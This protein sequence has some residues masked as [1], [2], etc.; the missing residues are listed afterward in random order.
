MSPIAKVGIGVTS[1]GTLAT[2]GYFGIS[3]LQQDTAINKLIKEKFEYVLL[4]TSQ[5]SGNSDNKHWNT[6]WTKY[7]NDNATA[8]TGKD[9]LQLNGWTANNQIDLTSELKKKC[10]A[11]AK[12]NE[13]VASLYEK[14]TKYCARGVTFEEQARKDKLSILITDA[15]GKDASIWTSRFTNKNTLTDQLSKLT[16]TD[17]STADKIRE[18]CETAKSKNKQVP[19]YSAVYEAY[20]KVCTKQA[21][22]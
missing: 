18:G 15:Q 14:I 9:F 2:T 21:G 8:T 6:K 10:E 1:L 16:I 22:E 3:Y 13:P 5:D 11:L 17:T 20:K 7:N 12:S 4:N 19:D